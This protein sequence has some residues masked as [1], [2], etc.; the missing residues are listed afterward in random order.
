M[1]DNEESVMR[2]FHPVH[3]RSETAWFPGDEGTSLLVAIPHVWDDIQRLSGLRAQVRDPYDRKLLLKYVFIEVR[4]LTELM[5]ALHAKVMSAETYDERQ[6]PLYRGI[7][8][9]ERAAAK[10]H[11]AKYSNAKKAVEDD[12]IAVRNKIG[13]HRD[14]IDW[15]V[16]TTLWDK[17]DENVISALLD[18]I[19]AAFNHAKDLN[20]FEW[21]RKPEPGV[22]E[23]LGGPVGPWH[24]DEEPSAPQTP[25]AV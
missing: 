10:D 18:T 24:F 21:N 8:S 17:L 16:V 12:I 23:I 5:D 13:A 22:I 11:W 6:E 2:V 7:S 19:P 25:N 20:I 15:R 9:A 3:E 14:S 4:S 1:D